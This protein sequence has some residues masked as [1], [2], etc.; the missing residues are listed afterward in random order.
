VVEELK[1]HLE[2]HIPV[3]VAVVLQVQ[4]LM[5]LLQVQEETAVQQEQVQLMEHQQQELEEV[6]VVH[7]QIPEV[8]QQVVVELVVELHWVQIIKK[9]ERPEQQ[10]LV[11]EAV[12]AQ[13][14]LLVVMLQVVEQVVQE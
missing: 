7:A 11:V 3:V 13:P 14:E 6:E 12:E 10:T 2:D 9:M 4:E 5:D 8:L 1:H